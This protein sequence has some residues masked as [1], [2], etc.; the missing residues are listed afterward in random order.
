METQLQQNTP[1]LFAWI[2]R[3][4]THE[5]HQQLCGRRFGSDVSLPFMFLR[6]YLEPELVAYLLK[7]SSIRSLVKANVEDLCPESFR[8]HKA[9]CFHA[10]DISPWHEE[11]TMVGFEHDGRH[12][13]VLG[14]QTEIKNEIA[15]AYAVS[16]DRERLFGSVT[17]QHLIDPICEQ[18]DPTEALGW[19]VDSWA[20]AIHLS[21]SLKGH[22]SLHLRSCP[23]QGSPELESE[24]VMN[25]G[26]VYLSSPAFFAH[27]VRKQETADVVAVQIRMALPQSSNEPGIEAWHSLAQRLARTLQHHHWHLPTLAQVREA[28]EELRNTVSSNHP[29]CRGAVQ[30]AGATI[31]CQ[32]CGLKGA[33]P[34]LRASFR[35]LRDMCL[36][37][38]GSAADPADEGRVAALEAEIKKWKLEVAQ[39]DQEIAVMV[40]MLTKQRAAERPFISAQAQVVAAQSNDANPEERDMRKG[41]AEQALPRPAATAAPFVPQESNGNK[42]PGQ[43]SKEK[44]DDK[45]APTIPPEEAADL[46]LDKQK[47]L[48]VFWDKV[49]KPPEAFKENKALLKDK[50]EQAQALGKEA[51][52]VKSE[53]D[54]VKTKLLRLRTERAMTAAGHD[55]SSPV[56][57]GP[58][59]MAE[60]QEIE[61][62][63]SLYR[64]KTAELRS[65]KSDVE[66]IQRMLEQN[67]AKVRREFENWFSGLRGR[68]N[69]SSLDDGKKKELLDKV[70]GQSGAGTPVPKEG[71]PEKV[72]PNSAATKILQSMPTSRTSKTPRE[73]DLAAYYAAFGELSA[74]SPDKK[75]HSLRAAILLAHLGRT[76]PV[77]TKTTHPYYQ[78]AI[79]NPLAPRKVAAIEGSTSRVLHKDNGEPQ[80]SLIRGDLPGAVPQRFK[81]HL[82]VNIYDP[83]EVTPYSL[84][85]GLHCSDIEGAQTGTRKGQV[86]AEASAVTQTSVQFLKGIQYQALPYLDVWELIFHHCTVYTLQTHLEFGLRASACL[87]CPLTGI[88]PTPGLLLTSQEN[89]LLKL[90]HELCSHPPLQWIRGPG[91]IPKL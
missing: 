69:M 60:V 76:I 41:S 73:E 14:M 49:Y 47:A 34:L 52:Q 33:F 83:P 54:V 32:R 27:E 87:A 88:R 64:E 37:K 6:G 12:S 70:T 9:K 19:H 46:L 39:R 10:V 59:E 63:K 90:I 51:L 48:E 82:P 28:K 11:V 85:T 56:E 61:R 81:G 38:Q 72:S 86:E 67:Q 1:V 40:K 17:I 16:V 79:D 65:A 57:D 15:L 26:D 89:A 24:L 35:I 53:I 75:C 45:V 5:H 74:F 71:A 13:A 7:D 44:R 78:E 42:R 84:F 55:D 22:R 18:A 77:H 36:E 21:L 31:C 25:P 30:G 8:G 91:V 20:S 68:A 80:A 50:I 29:R 62:L 23:G 3:N 2:P 43:A 66:G 4:A 58:E